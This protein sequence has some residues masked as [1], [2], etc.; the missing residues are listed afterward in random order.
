MTETAETTGT[1]TTRKLR[2]SPTDRMI[3]GVCGG[4]ARMLGVDAAI[5]RILLVAATIFGVGTPVLVYAVC[6]ILMPED[7]AT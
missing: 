6:W 5:L 4:W 7:D 3:A 1:T 2:R